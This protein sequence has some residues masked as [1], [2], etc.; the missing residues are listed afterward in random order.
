MLSNELPD[1]LLDDDDNIS[2]SSQGLGSSTHGHRTPEF[3]LDQSFEHHDG[4]DVQGTV[5]QGGT[6]TYYHHERPLLT[7]RGEEFIRSSGFSGNGTNHES[8]PEVDPDSVP[9]G[10]GFSAGGGGGT[11]GYGR[12][13]AEQNGDEVD[14]GG[15]YLDQGN[16]VHDN[17]GY[18]GSYQS[19]GTNHVITGPVGRDGGDSD[20]WRLSHQ[21]GDQ[22]VEYDNGYPTMHPTDGTT[23][24]FVVPPGAAEGHSVYPMSHDL[25]FNEVYPSHGR[26]GHHLQQVRI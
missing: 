3:N 6:A 13:L 11:Y 4:E 19:D 18:L 25:N 8:V 20:N 17:H 26:A 16:D 24:D 21:D 12:E 2:F 7:R 14:H 1:E 15:E 22:L 10:Y 23:A 5:G 9:R